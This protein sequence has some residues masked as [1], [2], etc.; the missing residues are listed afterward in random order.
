MSSLAHQLRTQIRIAGPLTVAEFMA[1]ALDH[2]RYGYYMRGDP[3]GFEGDFIT[4][5][6][7]SQMFGELIGLWCAAEWQRMERPGRVL[8]VELGPG[9]GTLMADALRAIATLPGCR[10]AFELHLVETSPALRAVQERT[11]AGVDVRWHDGLADVPEGPLLLVA[12]ELFDALPIHQ[13]VRL[14]GAWRERLVD[15]DP[16]SGRFRF[17]LAPG[18]TPAVALLANQ[19][20]M[21]PPNSVAE[22]SPAAIGLGHEIGRRVAASGGRAL[23]IDYA[24]E[25]GPLGDTLQAVRRHDRHDVLD[26]PGSA[27]LSARVDFAALA[28]VIGEAGARAF[29]PVN[30]G[31]FLLALG[32]EARAAA[33]AHNADER[34]RADIDAALERLIAP[35]M[36]G[37]LFKALAVAPVD[38]PTPAGFEEAPP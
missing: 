29:G 35:G 23:V 37:T 38:A 3:F 20:N 22:V 6:E 16:D 14:P 10:E 4:A 28:R 30:Q 21:A 18:P 32:I 25:R 12:N 8:L 31:D 36:M 9:R 5:P 13:F 11:F 27:D 1:A 2:P 33:L 24:S 34:Q 17:V 15:A 26:D 7:V 19:E